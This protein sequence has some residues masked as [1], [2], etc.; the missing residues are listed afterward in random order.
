MPITTEWYNPEKT[1][2]LATFDGNWS[3]DDYHAFL[4]ESSELILSVEHKVVSIIDLSTSGPPP[5][6]ILSTGHRMER[7]DTSKNRQTIILG[8]SR[9]LEMVIAM[10]QRI[11]PKLIRDVVVVGTWE[12]AISLAEA[13]LLEEVS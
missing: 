13:S 3:L 1:I 11:F 2:L 6:R 5:A 9:Q 12:E 8:M 4:E 10:F 7:L